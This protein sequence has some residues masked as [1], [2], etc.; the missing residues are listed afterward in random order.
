MTQ[1]NFTA[2]LELQAPAFTATAGVLKE[3]TASLTLQAPAFTASASVEGGMQVRSQVWNGTAWVTAPARVWD[4][5]GWVMVPELVWDGT[6]W[7]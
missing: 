2:S 5:S 1:Q 7:V 3:F 6:A 4:G